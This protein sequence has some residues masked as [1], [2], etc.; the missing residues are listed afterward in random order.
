MAAVSFGNKIFFAGGWYRKFDSPVLYCDDDGTNCFYEPAIAGSNRVDIYDV[1][2]GIRSAA[3]LS[4]GRGDITT[5]IVDNRILFAGGGSS[6]R[7][8]IYDALTN[9]WST[10]QLSNPLND[11]NLRERVHTVGQKVIATSFWSNIV[12]IYDAMTNSWSTKQMGNPN[13]ATDYFSS[14]CRQ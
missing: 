7:I 1:S 10:G 3:Q 9:S 5:A 6:K 12:D 13:G 2:S 14:V 4:E 8:D 11:P